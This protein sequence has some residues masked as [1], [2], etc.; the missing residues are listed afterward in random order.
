MRP[1]LIALLLA[2]PATAGVYSPTDDFIF[3]IDG[4]GFARP[5]QF[6]GGF[7]I[8]LNN[9]RAVAIEKAGEPV[10]HHRAAALD[11][12][13]TRKAKGVPNLTPEELA[14]YTADL[15]RAGR[16][17]EALNLLQPLTRGRRAGF[18]PYAHLARA[19]AGRGEWREAADQQSVALRDVDFPEKFGRLSPEQL[20]W[21]KRV[22]R[23]YYLPLLAHRADE[24]RFTRGGSAPEDVDPLFP[25]VPPPRR[26]TDPVRF[27][28]PNGDY[29]PG[30]MPEAERKKLPPD[31]LAIVQQLVLWHPQDARLYWLLGELY[32]AEGEVEA[33]AKIMDECAF[34]MG[35]RSPVLR[36]HKLILQDAASTQA[37]TRAEEAAKAQAA[38]A[39]EAQA[40]RDAERDYQKRKWWIIACAVGLGVLLVYYQAREV[41]RRFRR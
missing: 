26:P 25:P 11:R 4:Q 14:G 39:A 2:A 9:T 20:R 41:V 6:G 24:A 12:I 31:A 16:G 36:K 21:L 3:E 32:N 38:Q 40:A 22:E 34:V 33:A 28:E 23:D 18:I 1:I 15:I 27:E 7:E 29:K 8:F 35:Y 5:V 17:D 19:H 37:K 13:R 10:N 30:S